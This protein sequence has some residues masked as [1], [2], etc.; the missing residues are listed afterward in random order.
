MDPVG[1]DPYVLAEPEAARAVGPALQR[2][3]FRVDGLPGP[4]EETGHAQLL[5]A[6]PDAT[7][8]AV[9]DP[10]ADGEAAAR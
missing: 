4:S 5:V 7:F 10:R 2:A 8:A 3:G 9:A 1:P 6:A